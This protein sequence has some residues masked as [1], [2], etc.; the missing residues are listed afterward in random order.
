MAVSPGMG[1]GRSSS[2][3]ARGAPGLAAL[4]LVV[5]GC[6]AQ[7]APSVATLSS[8]AVGPSVAATPAVAGSGTPP[9]ARPRPTPTPG[10]PADVALRVVA[11]GLTAP[12]GLVAAPDGSGRSF[13]LD[14]TGLILILRDGRLEEGPFLDIRDR[15]VDLDPEYDERGL[16]GLAFH[17]AFPDDP[18]VFVYY[19]APTRDGAAAGQD[20]TNTLVEFRVEPVGP[21]CRA[22]PA[23]RRVVLE[24][25][26]PQPNHSGGGARLRA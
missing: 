16:L 5:A 14:Q 21:G 18:R 4:L 2:R 11:D 6:Q 25:E 10:P 8:A 23:S 20:H 9:T 22:D 7:T 15:I 3:R 1:S 13:V 26:Q 24:F 12:V 17:P 19:G